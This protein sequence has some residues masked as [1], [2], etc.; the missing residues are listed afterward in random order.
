MKDV[1]GV[2]VGGLSPQNDS[3]RCNTAHAKQQKHDS[4]KLVSNSSSNSDSGFFSKLTKRFS[5]R[6]DEHTPLPPGELP[7]GVSEHKTSS[8]RIFFLHEK[9]G[10]VIY[11]LDQLKETHVQFKEENEPN[12]NGHQEDHSKNEIHSDHGHVKLADYVDVFKTGA[13]KSYYYS[14]NT[15]K[16]YWSLNA[17]NNSTAEKKFLAELDAVAPPP[18]KVNTG[19]GNSSHSFSPK[20]PSLPPPKSILRQE[21]ES[22]KQVIGETTKTASSKWEKI[23]DECSGYHYCYD[24]QTGETSWENPDDLR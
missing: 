13:G 2:I 23:F 4:L 5:T 12:W 19:S 11:S 3:L 21:R 10:K 7:K 22:G 1:E 16:T 24:C 15:G 6:S 14:R 17:L 8:G 9:T 20:A 18:L